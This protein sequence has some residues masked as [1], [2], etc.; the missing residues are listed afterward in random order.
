MRPLLTITASD[1]CRSV[2][3]THSSLTD[4]LGRYGHLRLEAFRVVRGSRLEPGVEGDTIPRRALPPCR[5]ERPGHCVVD[6]RV[7]LCATLVPY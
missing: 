3:E 5:L 7:D 6:A 2:L 1:R 4:D